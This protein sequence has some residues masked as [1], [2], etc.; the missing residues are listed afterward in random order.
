MNNYVSAVC[1]TVHYHIRAL[2]HIR[3]SM[4][5][6]MAKMVACA[7]AGSRHDNASCLVWNHSEKNIFKLQKAQNRLARVV[8]RPP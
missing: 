5:E 6:Y 2:R 7:L 3:S 1:K 8:T 4:S